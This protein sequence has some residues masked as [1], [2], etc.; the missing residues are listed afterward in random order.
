MGS[1]TWGRAS[2]T[3]THSRARNGRQHRATR[4]IVARVKQVTTLW[5]AFGVVALIGLGMLGG[6][7]F[8]IVQRETGTRAQATV[9]GCGPGGRYGDSNC[10]GTW[11]VGG[12][13]IS[14]GQVVTGPIDGASS[15][16]VGKTLDVTIRGD[17]A[18]TRS[19]RLPIILLV[20]G[21]LIAVVG[22]LV[23]A[24]YA[25]QRRRTAAAAPVSA[26][27]ASSGGDRPVEEIARRMRALRQEGRL[28]EAAALVDDLG[29]YSVADDDFDTSLGA[30]V[31]AAYGDQLAATDP[32]AADAAYHRAAGLQ[33][34][35]AGGASSGSEGLSR[36]AIAAEFESRRRR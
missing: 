31:L 9:V 29:P 1:P 14:G 5:L 12:S 4:G 33:I 20:L 22:I 32:A 8:L 13:L 25:R 16:D 24:S 15:D 3:G 28:A 18:Y 21:V 26:P 6:G 10:Y 35:F 34:A 11:V 2:S 27:V 30:A 7:V 17:H 19:L 23:P 36:S